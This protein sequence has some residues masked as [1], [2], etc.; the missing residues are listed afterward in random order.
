MMGL[1]EIV[2]IVG[3]GTYWHLY[4]GSVL[5]ELRAAVTYRRLGGETSRERVDS[6]TTQW[7]PRTHRGVEGI[8]REL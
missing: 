8:D 4:E 5:H 2:K 3:P 7:H 6:V 1:S